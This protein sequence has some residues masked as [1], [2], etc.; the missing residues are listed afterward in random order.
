MKATKIVTLAIL[1]V[2]LTQ[3]AC[4]RTR[5]VPLE[6]V[7]V[8]WYAD[9]LARAWADSVMGTLTM[10]ERIAQSIVV[11]AY[12]NKNEA[13]ERALVQEVQRYGVGGVLFFQGTIERQA[14]LTNE[15]QRVSKVPLL[16]TIDAE[17]GLGMRLIDG[18]EYP[19]AMAFAATGE[20]HFA[21]RMGKDLATQM[22]RLGVHV[23]F[24]PVADINTDGDNP[25]I[26]VRS[27]GDE[28]AT[29]ESFACAYALGLEQNGALSCLKHFPG[30]GNTK[31]DSHKGLPRIAASREELDSVELR[32]FKALASVASMVMLGHMD[33]PAVTGS[34][35]GMPTSLSAQSVRLLREEFG[36]KGLICT[37]ALNMQGVVAGKKAWQV[38]SMAYEAGVDVLLCVEQVEA[39]LN[40]IEQL[41]KKGKIDT[42]SI[43]AR[44]RRVL[45]AKYAVV[46]RRAGEVR[47]Q[48]LYEDLHRTEYN[49]LVREVAEGGVVLL[50]EGAI[51]FDS[52]ANRKMGYVS[53]LS[54]DSMHSALEDYISVPRLGLQPKAGENDAAKIARFVK[55]KTHLVVAVEAMGTSPSGGFGLLSKLARIRQCAAGCPT[56]VV[57]FGSPYSLRWL[58][59][60]KG[61][62]G[63][64]LCCSGGV[65]FQQEAVRVLL[66][67]RPAEGRL[68]VRVSA[69]LP[70]GAGTPGKGSGRLSYTVPSRM[71]LNT[72]MLAR[73]DSLAIMAIDS[74]A[75][76]GMQVLAG[77]D[78]VI[79]YD[80]QFGHFTYSA[81]SPRVT[82]STLYDVAS[83]T[84]VVVTV[85]VLMSEMARGAISLGDTLGRFLHGIDT[86]EACTAHVGDVLL[87]QAGLAAYA[88]FYLRTV[89]S[90]FPGRAVAQRRMSGEYCIDVGSYG[91]MSKHAVPSDRFYRTKRDGQFSM[92]LSDNLYAI[93]TIRDSVLRSIFTQPLNPKQGYKYSDFGYILLGKAVES[94]EGKPLDVLADSV[95]FR[96]LGMTTTM[97]CPAQHG[98][99]RQCAPTENEVTF[100]KGVVQGYVHDLTAAMLGGVSGHAGLFSTSHDLAKYAQMLLN[101]GKY[102][103]YRFFSPSMVSLFTTVPKESINGRRTYGF[104][105]R[106]E[107]ENGGA[108][109]GDSLSV[110]S[111][112]HTG[113]T[114]TILWIDPVK[115]FFFVLLSNRVYPDGDNQ[116]INTLKVRSQIMDA[117]YRA[118]VSY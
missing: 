56:T 16:V 17:W 67:V 85:P 34:R 113:F 88:P 98:A 7:K 115:R 50:R 25:I 55:D 70:R 45:Q 8:P 66:G 95:L 64:V 99:K 20:P 104:D 97:F 26:G 42:A 117:L 54:V 23:N 105:T 24:A 65:A 11:S 87:H 107:K 10:R 78:G 106:V 111:Y 38:N 37:D 2:A 76:P 68:P 15:L 40:R 47:L 27:F 82:D 100:R 52:V 33:V 13:Y 79:F 101:G 39:T 77:C 21:Y 109:V 61:V 1:L 90:L 31:V 14:Q 51:P 116:R 58:D 4:G 91:F 29:V 71:V 22:R 96:P 94:V 30:H 18:L 108:L 46:G 32:P 9:S 110:G 114:G 93:P 72:D 112:G 6:E 60:V 80:R 118:V 59:T 44:A 103:G 43:N 69:A 89:E 19:K 53:F 63:L 57:V 86:G 41:V 84:K 92:A 81:T 5:T 102:G 62:D 3:A 28:A 35:F 75:M 12:S 48:N 36:F 49:E 73:A 74:Q 83:L